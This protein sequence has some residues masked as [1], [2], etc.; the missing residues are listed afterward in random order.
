MYSRTRFSTC[1]DAA[2]QIGV[3]NV[4]S[5]TKGAEMPSTPT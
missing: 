4:D 3:R 1:H 2:M 5:S